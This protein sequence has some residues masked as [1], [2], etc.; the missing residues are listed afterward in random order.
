M[1][2]ALPWHVDSVEAAIQRIQT[3]HL[4]V[5]QRKVENLYKSLKNFENNKT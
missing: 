1:E 4:L 2:C 5:T 3:R